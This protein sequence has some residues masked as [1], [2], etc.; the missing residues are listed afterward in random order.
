MLFQTHVFLLFLAIFFFFWS[1]TPKHRIKLIGVASILF[2]E[3]A[4]S[5]ES[6]VAVWFRGWIP[7]VGDDRSASGGGGVDGDASSVCG[8]EYSSDEA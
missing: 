2:Y 3:W 8:C 1:K 7:D 5:D 6:F 4:A